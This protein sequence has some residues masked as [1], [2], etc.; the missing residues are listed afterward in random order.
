M[1]TMHDSDPVPKV[2]DFGVSKAISQPL[3][4]KT[5]HTAYGQ[6]VGTPV[7]MSPEQAQYS[8]LDIDTRSDI[9]S[10]GVLL[11]ELLTGTTPLDAKRLREVGFAEMVR[12]IAEEESPTPSTRLSSLSDQTAEIA[13]YRNTEP[14]KLRQFLQGDLDWVV[15]R[16]L[17]KERSRRYQTANE[18]ALDIGRYLDNKPI[19]ARPQTFVY[20]LRK[21][22]IR[23]RRAFGVIT[24]FVTLLLVSVAVSGFLAFR[25]TAEKKRADTLRV[26]EGHQRKRAEEL[27]A[28]SQKQLVR[29]YVTT[30]SNAAA[31]KTS[32]VWE[33]AT[34]RPLSPPMQHPTFVRYA[35]LSPD[36]SR[37][38]TITS[39]RKVRVWDATSGDLLVPALPPVA[40]RSLTWFSED[41]RSVIIQNYTAGDVQQWKLPSFQADQTIVPDLVKLLS[42]QTIDETDG[43]INLDRSAARDLTDAFNNAWQGW[44]RD[45]F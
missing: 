1:V 7:Y 17:E 33:A 28:Q 16:A 38:V 3:T 42:A 10:L 24:A 11:Y 43:I 2:I 34:G 27:A 35:D 14:K 20:R 39:S 32:R 8:G 21:A 37:V 26:K 9:Y 45:R 36:G 23:H 13:T 25:A 44:Q 15:M 41:G 19:D 22:A 29:L 31:H 4:E 30:G 6:M 5:L 18:L 12:A 40:D